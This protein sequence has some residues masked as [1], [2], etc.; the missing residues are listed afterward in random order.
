MQISANWLNREV[1]ALHLINVNHDLDVAS[2]VVEE[3]IVDILFE[4]GNNILCWRVTIGQCSDQDENVKPF[5]NDLIIKAVLSEFFLYALECDL[6][7]V[8]V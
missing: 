4:L 1:Y 6:F 2:V 7:L 3:L 5:L 8:H